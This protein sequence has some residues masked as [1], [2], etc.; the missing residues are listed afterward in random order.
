M[1]DFEDSLAPT[2]RNVVDGQVNLKDAVRGTIEFQFAG[3]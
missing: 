2:W 3:R 1:A